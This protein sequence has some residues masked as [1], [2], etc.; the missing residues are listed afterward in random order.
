[1]PG[2]LTRIGVIRVRALVIAILVCCATQGISQNLLNKQVSGKFYDITLLELL[3]VLELQHNIKIYY[4]PAKLPFYKQSIELE[5]TALYEAMDLILEGS[6][7][8]LIKY[9]GALFIGNKYTITSE[10]L[11]AIRQKWQD[12]IFVKPVSSTPLEIVSTLGDSTSPMAG[13]LTIQGVIKEQYS[14]QP[15]VGALIQDM[16]TGL[17]ESTDADGHFTLTGKAG[18]HKF[19]ISY[20]GYQDISWHLHWF[21][22]DTMELEM[23]VKTLDLEA[24]VVEATSIQN[25][26]EE[27]QIG[28]EAISMK[29]V[30]ELPSFLGEAD[31]IRSIEQL[32]GVSSAGEA[33][34]GFNVRGGNIDQNLILLD[35]AILFN[36]SHA[37]GIFSIFNPNAVR[38]ANLYKGNIPAQYGGRLSSVLDVELK[39]ANRKKWHGSGGMG[40][41]SA[42]IILDGPLTKNSSIL[43]GARTSYNGWLLKSARKSTI[44]GSKVYFGDAIFKVN[45]QLAE[46]HH[47]D[48][49]VYLSDDHFLFSNEFGY[50]WSSAIANA[51]W[52]FLVSENVSLST[53]AILG[54]YSSD[55]YVPSGDLA[56]NRNTGIDYL[57]IKSNVSLQL[58]NHFVN[59]G[60][61]ATSLDMKPEI[62]DPYHYH[63]SIA[64]D[65]IQRDQGLDWALYINDEIEISD[66]F[67]IAA[68]IRMGQYIALGPQKYNR[69]QPQSPQRQEFI[70]EEIEFNKNEIVNAYF[71]IE[72][73]ISA[74]WKFDI[75]HALKLSYNRLRQAIHLMSNTSSASPVDTWQL[76]NYHIRPQ[77]SDNFSVGLFRQLAEN[78]TLSIEG[79]YKRISH[80]PQF[81][82]FA[83]LL[84]NP[85]LER[86]IVEAKG[87]TKGVEFALK[88]SSGKW[89]GAIAYTY[90]SSQ[91]RT[92][93]PFFSEQINDNNWFFSHYDAPHQ[94]SVLIKNQVDPV[95]GFQIS[96]T[97]RSGRPITVPISN[98]GIQ[99]IPITHFSNRNEFR[100]PPYH[101]LDFG[102]TIDRSAAKY[103]GM[104]SSVSIGFYNVYFRKNPYTIYFRRDSNN[105]QQA[106]KLSVLGTIFP[107]LNWNI[108]F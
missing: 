63:S 28:V 29:E 49:T 55:Q 6:R 70:V 90:S 41:A 100:V 33:S 105:A 3:E 47:A 16:A 84:G 77:T 39:D 86:E 43:F 97:Y 98:Y 94:I 87:R 30:R 75:R 8:H 19:T 53:R 5:E 101:R 12:G 25:K 21:A 14:G 80:L 58:K 26:V 99:N 59:A 89:S 10:K 74:S 34:G 106:Y 2:M 48:F 78:S 45:H 31:I 57:K 104:K 40:I 32:P 62:M 9:D 83:I 73:R 69:Y 50:R 108:S 65:S 38:Q 42:R 82:D 51:R 20:L 11:N 60:F 4:D 88:K 102:Y 91:V 95:Q 23:Q 103:K 61:E 107:S 96:F 22:S 56:F 24:V 13:E 1:M 93:S 52:R 76:S 64:P 92:L 81:R 67:S 36:A 44:N 17:G 15:I 71:G 27:V 72:P 37:L 68:G 7:L 35:E 18:Q 66:Q 79:F 46:K 85:S 54:K